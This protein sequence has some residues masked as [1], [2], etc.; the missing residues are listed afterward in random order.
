M[1]MV[2][3][4]MTGRLKSPMQE[5]FGCICIAVWYGLFV[6]QGTSYIYPSCTISA[7]FLPYSL[8]PLHGTRTYYCSSDS[9]LNQAYHLETRFGLSL[10]LRPARDSNLYSNPRRPS[11]T[12]SS[13]D[14]NWACACDLGL[15]SSVL[16]SACQARQGKGQ[17]SEQELSS[18]S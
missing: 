7:P 9:R 14:P 17:E 18:R 8:A 1:Q 15:G 2:T 11:T 4:A 5:A 6:K 16:S 12:L 3:F 13:A 10:P